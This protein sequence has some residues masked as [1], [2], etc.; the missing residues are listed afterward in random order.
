MTGEVIQNYEDYAGELYQTGKDALTGTP[1]Q[2][3]GDLVSQAITLTSGGAAG[4]STVAKAATGRSLGD[5]TLVAVGI[6]L[7][8]GALLI[9]AK[10]TVIKAVG[11]VKDA[12]TLS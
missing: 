5:Y 10:P 3:A 4:A 7:A 9:S 6:I 2:V 11:T 12:A 1:T 8:L